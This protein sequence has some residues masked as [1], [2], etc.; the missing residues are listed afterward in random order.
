[1][2]E[3][4]VLLVLLY[5]MVLFLI[6]FGITTISCIVPLVWNNNVNILAAWDL[7]VH[8][9]MTLRTVFYINMFHTVFISVYLSLVSFKITFAW[10]LCHD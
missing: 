6:F 7:L 8:S 4:Y 5:F 3:V 2:A 1:M 10:W 9:F